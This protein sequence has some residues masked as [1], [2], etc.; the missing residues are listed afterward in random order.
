MRRLSENELTA[1]RLLEEA[2]G[3]LIEWR[4]PDTNERD[5]VFGVVTP[6]HGVYRKLEKL[7]LVFYTDEE[8]FDLPGD[9]LDGF[10]FSR[11]IY[12]EDAGRE[13]LRTGNAGVSRE[14][15]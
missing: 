14:P 9:P 15:A 7:G 1:L 13:A 4:V 11:E 2:G 10:T 8:P 6:G 3:S 5:P 12:I